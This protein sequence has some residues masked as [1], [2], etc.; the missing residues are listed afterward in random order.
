MFDDFLDLVISSK[1]HEVFE[2]VYF[3]KNLDT[4]IS[5]NSLH[6]IAYFSE[7]RCWWC[8]KNETFRFTIRHDGVTACANQI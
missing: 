5:S 1:L 4:I 8:L 7:V 3:L 6:G 2:S